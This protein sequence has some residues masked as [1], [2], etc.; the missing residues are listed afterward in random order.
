M[1]PTLA[2]RFEAAM[3]AQPRISFPRIDFPANDGSREKKSIPDARGASLGRQIKRFMGG[4]LFVILCVGV[5]WPLLPRRYESTASV[6]LRPTDAEG[7]LDSVQSLRQPLDD[8]AIQSEMDII[9]SPTIASAVIA[10]HRLDRDPEFAGDPNRL[11]MRL[12][13]SIYRIAPFVSEWLG[14]PRQV[15]E[16]GLRER[17]QKHLTVSRDRRSYTVKMGYWS[18]DPVKAAALTE[19]LLNA[20]LSNQ[21]ARKR[22]SAEQHSAWLIERVEGLR[23]KY[24]NSERAVREFTL[25]SDP[26]DSAMLSSLETQRAALGQEA[27]DLRAKLAAAVVQGDVPAWPRGTIMGG[28]Q[29]VSGTAQASNAAVRAWELRAAVVDKALRTVREEI[30]DRRLAAL[31][32]EALRREEA[33]DKEL[34]DGALV[35]LKEQE[36]RTSSTGP[37][38]EILARPDPALRPS[39]PNALLFLFGTLVAAVA[40]GAAMVWNPGAGVVRRALSSR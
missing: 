17:L 9:G 3:N 23:G 18:A 39:F 25:Q 38:V 29:P 40:A 10:H 36:P 11:S 14:D 35:R 15:S 8:N 26:S 27:A 31:R 5:A 4:F 7:R 30:A 32:L 6:I 33:I 34:L 37:G 12:L 22:G 20:Y 1:K 21:L 19:T 24:E 16:A 28:S 13:E 2:D